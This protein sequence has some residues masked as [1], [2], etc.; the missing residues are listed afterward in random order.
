MMTLLGLLAYKALKG[1]SGQDA[2]PGGMSQPAPLPSGSN[3]SRASR[4][5]QKGVIRISLIKAGANRASADRGRG[6]SKVS[7]IKPRFR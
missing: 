7:Q 4:A 6:V 1:R 5:T 2:T 3:M